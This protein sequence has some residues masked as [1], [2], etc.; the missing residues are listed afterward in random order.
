MGLATERYPPACP[1]TTCS[2]AARHTVGRAYWHAGQKPYIEVLQKTP[3]ALCLMAA[4]YETRPLVDSRGV[5][6]HCEPHSHP[7]PSLQ[8]RD[9]KRRHLHRTCC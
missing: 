3:K 2:Q 8:S 9:G 7:C 5:N 6:K 4:S 1:G